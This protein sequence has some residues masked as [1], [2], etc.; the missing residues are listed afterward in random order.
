MLQLETKENTGCERKYSRTTSTKVN[1]YMKRCQD[2]ERK[3]TWREKC[4]QGDGSPSVVTIQTAPAAQG[5]VGNV[6]YQVL[7][8]TPGLGHL[9]L[10]QW[11]FLERLWNLEGQPCQRKRLTEGKVLRVHP[12][13]SD[14]SLASSMQVKCGQPAFCPVFAAVRALFSRTVINRLSSLNCFGHGV[15]SSQEKSDQ[16]GQ[17]S[18]PASIKDPPVSM[19]PALRSQE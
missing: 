11:C 8:Q 17:A 9:V 5:L 7:I 15:L 14:L 13:F 19:S 10:S 3:N 12:T 18:W 6:N 1:A 2:M 4:L 16:H